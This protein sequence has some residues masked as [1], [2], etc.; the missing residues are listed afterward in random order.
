MGGVFTHKQKIWEISMPT[1]VIQIIET[2][3]MRDRRDLDNGDEL[4]FVDRFANENDFAATLH[5]GGITGVAQE[6]NK[7]GDDND[8]G[9]R[10][11][12]PSWNSPWACSSLRQNCRS[13]PPIKPNGT[14]RSGPT[15]KPSGTPR[16][17]PIIKRG[18]W[19]CCTSPPDKLLQQK[20]WVWWREW[21]YRH[22]H[23]TVPKVHTPCIYAPNGEECIQYPPAEENWL[24]ERKYLLMDVVC[25]SWEWPK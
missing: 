10:T 9:Q 8:N 22:L 20:R 25:T 4:L 12:Q 6:N 16:S 19:W 13:S 2:L 17:G 11:R 3:T 5:E 18:R 23:T 24:R 21:G 14:P 1:C 15:I 7:K